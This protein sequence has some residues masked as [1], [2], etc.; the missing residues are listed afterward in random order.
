M[1]HMGSGSASLVSGITRP[2]AGVRSTEARGSIIMVTS[3]IPG[4]QNMSPH[5]LFV[6][7]VIVQ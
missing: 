5:H 4:M 3:I 7:C 1:G 6:L 2:E